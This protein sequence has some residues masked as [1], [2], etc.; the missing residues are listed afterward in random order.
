MAFWSLKTHR[1]DDMGEL[2]NDHDPDYI[3]KIKPEDIDNE[4][5]DRAKIYCETSKNKKCLKRLPAIKILVEYKKA[6]KAASSPTE[7]QEIIKEYNN[8]YIS[9]K[10]K[11]TKNIGDNSI[12]TLN[13]VEEIIP[14]IPP[15]SGGSTFRKSTF[16]KS[17][18]KKSRAKS[19]PRSNTRT[20]K[21]TLKNK[22]KYCQKCKKRH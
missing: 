5:Y 12:I 1:Y 13:P 6:L 2:L 19:H 9:K 21:Y 10:S 3:R 15:Q 4:A 22:A 11:S 20:R 14:I 8:K 7:K 18:F 16:R 17:T